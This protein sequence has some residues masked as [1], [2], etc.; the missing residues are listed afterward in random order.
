MQDD[1]EFVRHTVPLIFDVPSA[2][3]M[4]GDDRA[5]DA[6]NLLTA[7]IMDVIAAD[8]RTQALLQRYGIEWGWGDASWEESTRG[9]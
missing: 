7:R 8:R 9:S 5:V 6:L 4:R 1:Q 3:A 2:L